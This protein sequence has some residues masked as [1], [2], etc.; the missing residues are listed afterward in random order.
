MYFDIK[1]QKRP[2]NW[3]MWNNNR[4]I[5]Q[6]KRENVGNELGLYLR[7]KTNDL[8]QVLIKVGI[9]YT[10]IANAKLNLETEIP[11]W[12]FDS[13]RKKAN[14]EWEKQLGRIQ[15]EDNNSKNKEIFYTA[16]YHSLLQ[17]N[18][19]NDVNGDYPAYKSLETKNTN[20]K[21]ERYTVFSLWDTYR[22]LHPLL[23]LV[24]PERQLDMVKSML[25][26]YDEGGW[27]PKW[28]INGQE[29][30]VMVGDPASIV[31]ADSYL[32]G[33]D[34]FDAQKALTAM[35]KNV[36]TPESENPL[37]PGIDS[38]NKYGYIPQDSKGVW[39]P[40]STAQEYGIADWNIAQFASA[41]GEKEIADDLNKKS[42]LYRNYF[43]NETKFLR[44][45][46]VDGSFIKDFKL[47][48]KGNLWPGNPGFV[49]GDAWQYLFFPPHDISW[50]KKSIGGNKEFLKKLDTAMDSAFFIME[51]EPDMHYPYLYNTVKGQE[52]KTQYWVNKTIRENFDTTPNGLPGNDDC[53]TISAWLVFSMMG[54]YPTCP[55]NLNYEI[56]SPYFDK[57]TIKLNPEFYKGTE[58]TISIKKRE[59]SSI[60]IKSMKLNG[61]NYGKFNIYHSDVVNGG[62]FELIL[63]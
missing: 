50:L 15:I 46:I 29:S 45:R 35:L 17:P 40:L 39:G 51:N 18:I 19:L 23:S 36:K 54:I 37:R 30:Y 27:L 62:D 13:L 26:M 11:D 6:F 58:F 8:E 47:V 28:E 25:A 20:G 33:L 31:I 24:Y 1:I 21:F 22:T 10:S 32:R 52:W 14:D 44:P 42:L 12:D 49:E 57:V 56:T 53:G 38:L 16:L 55:G 9:S 48:L 3:G 34:N 43:D 4:D 7:Y 63:K 59:N 2:D 5:R 61:R 60:Y 41:L